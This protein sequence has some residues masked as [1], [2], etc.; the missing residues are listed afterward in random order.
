MLVEIVDAKAPLSERTERVAPGIATIVAW[1]ANIGGPN[2]HPVLRV[3]V[4]CSSVDKD[5]VAAWAKGHPE[6]TVEELE[7][8]TEDAESKGFY[9]S[10]NSRILFV[11]QDGA[12]TAVEPMLRRAAL[13][14]SLHQYD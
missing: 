12:L 2:Y 1:E 8:P 4:Y 5:E 10:F 14:A 6:R 3:Y 7:G 13:L 9:L 11:Q